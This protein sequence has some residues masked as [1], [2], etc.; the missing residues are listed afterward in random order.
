MEQGSRGQTLRTLRLTT[1]HHVSPWGGRPP[2]RE[3]APT[4]PQSGPCGR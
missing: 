3:D 2:C 1:S 4:A